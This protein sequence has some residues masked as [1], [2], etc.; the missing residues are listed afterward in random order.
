MSDEEIASVF[1]RLPS[2]ING[3]VPLVRRGRLLSE[4]FLLEAGTV[5]VHVTVREGAITDVRVS[6]PPM[7]P[8]RFAIRAG[9][10]AWRRFWQPVPLPGYHDILAMTRFGHAKIEGDL[11]PLLANLRYV[12]DVLAAPRRA[13]LEIDNAD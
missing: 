1:E 8:W 4:T 7:Q 12:K 2:L 13:G 6:P 3:D 11:Q 9:G 10:D 5:P